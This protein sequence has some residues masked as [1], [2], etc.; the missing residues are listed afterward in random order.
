MQITL[1]MELTAENLEKIKS[2]CTGA[3]V[4]VNA[5]PAVNTEPV[6]KRRAPKKE[7]EKIMPDES[8]AIYLKEDVSLMNGSDRKVLKAGTDTVNQM[9]ELVNAGWSI[10]EDTPAEVA[11]EEPKAPSITK[12]DLRAVALNLSKSGKSDILAQ[13]FKDFGAENLSG[14]NEADYP[15][16][17]ERLVEANA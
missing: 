11:K 8:K 7:A 10:A 3:E 13:I 9:Q 15:A 17:M 6:V 12:T 2:F 14:I 4:T 1:T 16:V 5:D